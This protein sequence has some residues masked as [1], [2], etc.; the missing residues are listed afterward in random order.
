M[1]DLLLFFADTYKRVF[2]FDDPPLHDP[3]A[4]AYVAA[5]E[6]FKVGVLL[7]EGSPPLHAA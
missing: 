4:V 7:P 1:H 6:L 5:P 2:S 3:V